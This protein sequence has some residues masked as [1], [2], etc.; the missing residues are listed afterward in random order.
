[1]KFYNKIKNSCK[2]FIDLYYL[3]NQLQENS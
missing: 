3:L 2:I 1:M